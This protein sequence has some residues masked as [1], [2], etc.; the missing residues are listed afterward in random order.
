M[1]TDKTRGVR[2]A[3][4]VFL[5]MPLWM[6]AYGQDA[7]TGAPEWKRLL[8]KQEKEVLEKLQTDT[9]WTDPAQKPGL[10][11]SLNLAR[12]LKMKSLVPVLMSHIA[13]QPFKDDTKRIYPMEESH[14]AYAAL[15]EIGISTVPTLIE[16]LKMADPGN[17]WGPGDEEHTLLSLCILDIYK[18]GG[19]GVEMA[20]KRIELE[21]NG[22]SDKERRLLQKTLDYRKYKSRNS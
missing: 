1:K 12:E 15:R 20:R 3:V 5:A 7:K 13:Y 19:C 14:P 4:F 10:I 17:E 8:E 16:R 18:Q 6:S 11:S 22:A 21:L 2:I 9:V